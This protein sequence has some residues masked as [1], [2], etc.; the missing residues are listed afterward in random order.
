MEK[1]IT[2]PRAVELLDLRPITVNNWWARG[3][4]ED[5]PTDYGRPGYPKMYNFES[6]VGLSVLADIIYF[7]PKVSLVRKMYKELDLLARIRSSGA[8]DN[9]LVFW[10]SGNGY[11]YKFAEKRIVSEIAD[12]HITVLI[13]SIGKI[14]KWVRNI[15]DTEGVEIIEARTKESTMTM[16]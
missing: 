2:N 6:L 13:L 12:N 10:R 1:Y 16:A 14:C 11:T 9:Q 8:T 15:I 3:M 5:I 4:F 7:L